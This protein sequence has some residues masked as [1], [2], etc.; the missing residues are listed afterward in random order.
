MLQRVVLAWA[1]LAT[2]LLIVVGVAA[3]NEFDPQPGQLR[4]EL[5]PEL[6]CHPDLS[7][8]AGAYDAGDWR[9]FYRS[10]GQLHGEFRVWS[11]HGLAIE[12]RYESG[13]RHGAFT[14]YRPDGSVDRIIQY[15]KGEEIGAASDED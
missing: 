15:S 13:K 1:I 3:F 8:E 2:T 9:G 10:C 4:S 14:F 6:D 11:D 5:G 12:G 7:A